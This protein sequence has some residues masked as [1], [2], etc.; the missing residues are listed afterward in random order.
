LASSPSAQGVAIVTNKSRAHILGIA[1]ILRVFV[2]VAIAIIAVLRRVLI[3]VAIVTITRVLNVFYAR[4][5]TKRRGPEAFAISAHC[6]SN[7]A[8][9]AALQLVDTSATSVPTAEA[10]LLS[11]FTHQAWMTVRVAF[12]VSLITILISITVLIA[13]VASPII[14]RRIVA[15]SGPKTLHFPAL[16]SRRRL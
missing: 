11:R 4:G 12:V 16:V 7:R 1:V 10:K 13:A 15:S 2:F 6:P 8:V 9:T 3:F 14:A 5:A